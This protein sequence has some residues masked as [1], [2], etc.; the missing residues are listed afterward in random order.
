[1]LIRR[2]DSA[3]VFNVEMEISGLLDHLAISFSLTVPH[4]PITYC[5]IELRR[6]KAMNSVELIQSVT[7]AFAGEVYQGSDI[8]FVKKNPTAEYSITSSTILHLKLLRPLSLDQIRSSI[9]W[10]FV[11]LRLFVDDLRNSGG[12]KNLLFIETHFEMRDAL[13]AT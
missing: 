8:E 9:T 11:E 1:M 13:L 12:R 2:E 7:S 3:F 6:I 5:K 10:Q 4:L